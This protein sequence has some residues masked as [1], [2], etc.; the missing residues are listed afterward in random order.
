MQNLL[1]RAIGLTTALGIV[2]VLLMM[3]HI[4]TDVIAKYLLG[5]PMPGTITVVSNY[6]MVL[7]AFLPLAFTE[8]KNAHISVEVITEHFPAWLQGGL[9]IVSLLFCLA[10]FGALTWQSWIEAG[11]ART[12]GAFEIE[13]NVKLLIWPA[14]YL[15]PLGCGLMT[16]TLLL[17][18]VIALRRGPVRSLE[19]PLF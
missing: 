2:A 9:K 16:A 12:V 15:L 13:Q 7:V 11:R 18:L 4:S 17:R 6:Y 1:G 19:E 14:R 8:R 5:M 3:L 10:I